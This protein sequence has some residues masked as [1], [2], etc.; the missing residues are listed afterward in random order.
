MLDE[1]FDQFDH[2]LITFRLTFCQTPVETRKVRCV[3][4]G[5]IEN[6]A[7]ESRVCLTKLKMRDE[8]YWGKLQ[9]QH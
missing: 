8:S 6:S 3:Y 2:V 9:Q 5:V 7:C 1:M 4:E